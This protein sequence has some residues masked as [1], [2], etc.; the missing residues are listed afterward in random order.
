[1]L[2]RFVWYQRL[3][4]VLAGLLI[5]GA[6]AVGLYERVIPVCLGVVLF[7][8]FLAVFTALWK[9]PGAWLKTLAPYGDPRD[10]LRRI[11]AEIMTGRE[12]RWF[13]VSQFWALYGAPA[14]VVLTAGWLL[15]VGPARITA[16]PLDDILWVFLRRCQSVP[17][18]QKHHTLGLRVYCRDDC[19]QFIPLDGPAELDAVLDELLRRRPGIAV[20]YRDELLAALAEGP[21][22]FAERV[23]RE[24]RDLS[25]LSAEER[26]AQHTDKM[27]RLHDEEQSL[28]RYDDDPFEG[29]AWVPRPPFGVG[30][31]WSI[32]TARK[33][34][35][36]LSYTLWAESRRPL[37][38]AAVSFVL[39]GFAI[40]LFAHRPIISLYG[41]SRHERLAHLIVLGTFAA[42]WAGVV[43]RFVYRGFRPDLRRRLA[44]FGDPVGV[45]AGIDGELRG[46]DVWLRGMPAY[47][48]LLRPANYI[49]V[50][51][52]WLLQV[53]PGGAVLVPLPHLAWVY[54]R[55]HPGPAW[56]PWSRRHYELGCRTR[57]GRAW[58]V[59]ADTEE[60]IDRLFEEVLERRP[61]VLVGWGGEC[62]DLLERGPA[63]VAAAYDAR[64]AGFAVLPPEKREAWLDESW[65]RFTDLVWHVE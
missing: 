59:V 63:A 1:M 22:N 7:F 43:A 34:Q 55:R 64:A 12:V 5:G 33:L 44:E 61:A 25:S 48:S 65:Q 32:A 62:L 19:W 15:R 21:T 38:W 47:A 14:F 46:G 9:Q 50:T 11:D 41:G 30:R 42:V 10:V 28:D 51:C 26:D 31:G 39:G 52:N 45:L 56:L 57:D 27:V 4:A 3:F 16:V 20:G 40:L 35:P 58:Y 37:A 23:G 49:A 53:R 13:G 18:E 6:V 29:T 36:R 2:E 17:K 24:Q 54:K 60:E 8:F